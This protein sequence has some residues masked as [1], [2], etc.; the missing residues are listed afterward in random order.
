MFD[1]VSS[2]RG[3]KFVLAFI[4]QALKFDRTLF[5]RPFRNEVW[6]VIGAGNFIIIVS[7]SLSYLLVIKYRKRLKSLRIIKSVAWLSYL[8][9]FIYYGGANKMFFTA[10]QTAPF[11]SRKDVMNA[12][13]E[14]KLKFRKGFERLFIDNAE[15]GADP[16]YTQ[17]WERAQIDLDEFRF[18]SINEGIR[19]I[20]EDQIVMH[21]GYNSLK[22]Y[23]KKFPNKPVPSI[24]PS[25]GEHNTA[26]FM[27]V[28]DNSPLGPILDQEFKRFGEIG[29]FDI[30]SIEWIGRDIPILME[31]ANPEALGQGQVAMVFVILFGAVVGSGI[32]L[33]CEHFYVYIIHSTNDKKR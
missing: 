20:S 15:K 32:T 31:T 19:A 17:F 6:V 10:K 9:V 21:I 8:L 24:I 26:E 18:S 28:T 27:I 16:T 12:Y 11:E 30:T 25:E 5:T 4:P 13:P 3:E 33:F 29:I 1:F 2:G 23:Y 7:F 14:W 22:Q